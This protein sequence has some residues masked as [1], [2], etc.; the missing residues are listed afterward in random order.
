MN[1]LKASG[2][3]AGLEIEYVYAQKKAKDLKEANDNA[4][5][6]ETYADEYD[7]LISYQAKLTEK[8]EA[9]KGVG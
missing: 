6:P 3:E 5:M 7:A 4:I 2:Y 8:E 1:T 9:D